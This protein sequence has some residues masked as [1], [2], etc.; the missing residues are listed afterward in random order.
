MSSESQLQD[1]IRQTRP[2]RSFYQEGAVA[3]LR[4]ADQVRAH[5]E[6]VLNPH[7]ITLQQYNVLRILR[8]VHPQSLPT[9]EIALRM[10]ECAPGITRLL[11]RL[12]GKRL[13]VRH[14]CSEDRRRVLC[15]VSEGALSL[16]E[17]LDAPIA[18]ADHQ[19]LGC[20]SESEARE[21]VRLLDRV[22]STPAGRSA[23][24]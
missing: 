15:N 10:I 22:R 17:Q 18:A 8:G 3:L 5:F 13:I 12:E 20:L 11:D 9:M 4:T 7:G 14:R 21:L 23:Q 16:L 1:E 19:V 2:F 24:A 6:H